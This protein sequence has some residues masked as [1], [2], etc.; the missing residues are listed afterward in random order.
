MR[1]ATALFRTPWRNQS[2]VKTNGRTRHT[3]ELPFFAGSSHFTRKNTRFHSCIQYNPFCSTTYTFRQ[4]L[5]LC[6]VLL[7][8]A[9]VCDVLLCDIL[10]CDVLLCDV[11][12]CD[13]LLCDV[14]L[15]DVLLCYV[16]LCDVLLCDMLL[17]DVLLLHYT[18][19]IARR[20]ASQRPLIIIAQYRI[21]YA[22]KHII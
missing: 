21:V 2:H 10:L 14:L 4:P 9:L 18:S 22:G 7:C 17:C 5:L 1:F 16:L 3:H 19:S 12:L 13:V 8:D 6:D 11:L 20:I 15:C